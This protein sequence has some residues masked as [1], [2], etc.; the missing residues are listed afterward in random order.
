MHRGGENF[1]RELARA[2]SRCRFVANEENEQQGECEDFVVDTGAVSSC[3][4]I[5]VEPRSQ[6]VWRRDRKYQ[7]MGQ[8]RLRRPSLIRVMEGFRCISMEE[9]G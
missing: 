5:V 8:N 1:S 9:T 6:L 4:G 3:F 2:S 7:G